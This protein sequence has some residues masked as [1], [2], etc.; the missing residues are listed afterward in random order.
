MGGR[1]KRQGDRAREEHGEAREEKGVA[2]K[3]W[4]E[5]R[6]KKGMMDTRGTRRGWKVGG[7]GRQ[8]SERGMG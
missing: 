7:A 8:E 2:M 5:G 4:T 1:S 3:R 6:K